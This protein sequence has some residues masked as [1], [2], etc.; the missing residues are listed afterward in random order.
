MSTATNPPANLRTSYVTWRLIRNQGWLFFL[1]GLCYVA[2]QMGWQ[3]PGLVTREVFNLLAVT[4]PAFNSLV[5]LI[6]ILLVSMVVRQAGFY[7]L[8]RFNVPFL[9]LN[10]TLL[11]KNM[12]Q[13][14]LR[15]PGA[16]AL[17]E[18][19]GEAVNRFK[20][21]A[22]EVP[23]FAL[24]M[25]NLI[26]DGLFVLIALVIMLSINV[27]VTL[28][29]IVPMIAVLIAANLATSRIERYRKATREATGRVM[30][31]I[32]ET[33]SSVQAIKVAGSEDNM[34]NH[35][36]ELNEVRRKAALIDRLFEEI[37]QSIFRNMSSLGTGILLILSA[38][39]IQAGTFKIGDFAL[40][41]YY[42]E[43]IGEFTG[44]LGFLSARY[45]QAGVSVSRMQRL[46]AGAPSP[47]LLTPGLVYERG[48]LP[49]VPYIA[50]TKADRLDT[51]DVAHLTYIHPT[52]GR[53]VR[54]VSL[55]VKR[56]G[57]TVITGRIGSGK[58]TLLRS[59]LG[60]LP[61]DTGDVRWNGA[62]VEN[63]A[64]FF[65]PP[66][67]A[68]TGQV[69]RLFSYSLRENLLMGLPEDKVDI[70]AAI[71]L[72]VMDQDLAMLEKGLD[73]MVGPKGVRLS[74][75]QIQR[76]AASRMFLRQPELLVF[77]DLSS[78]LDV[79][80]E[81]QLWDRV[82]AQQ[83]AT[84]LVVSHR[85]AALRRADHIIVLKDGQIESEG[86]LD[87]LLTRSDE[88]QR[89]WRGEVIAETEN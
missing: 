67:V 74:G 80:T 37:L 27:P 25:N 79:N 24:W 82:F 44:F 31:F 5:A 65:I 13:Q 58:T 29:A 66:R 75:G 45:K 56:G 7:G 61:K 83:G 86:T 18:T 40:F 38:Q 15:R 77:D 2:I 47:A 30:G 11:H 49:E 50:K 6:G 52:S 36:S 1:N 14:T 39:A 69:P 16:K 3:V 71:H 41:V 46:M 10:T 70:P 88:M 17:A 8:V 35:F 72:A 76:S 26:G 81:Q 23:L 22:N 4:N 12:L 68:Y 57:F 20:D 87:D 48:D 55:S 28:I 63:L 33:Y 85:Q 73:T 59:L 34:T 19:P 89:L 54:D 51:L 78:A 21:D 9:T 43:F 32:G 60:L 84:C 42:M 62:A 53:G 64:E